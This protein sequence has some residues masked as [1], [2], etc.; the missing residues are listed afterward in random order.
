MATARRRTNKKEA[1]E[2]LGTLEFVVRKGTTVQ[3]LQVAM[4]QAARWA[5]DRKK[6]VD[7]LNGQLVTEETDRLGA[8]KLAIHP[9]VILYTEALDRVEKFLVAGAKL[10]LDAM[11]LQLAKDQGDRIFD[12]F[13]RAIEAA[14]LAP[15]QAERMRL[16][17]ATEL[18]PP[19]E[20][21][22]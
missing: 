4:D 19:G 16:A 10:G 14:E 11:K 8:H 21:A 13:T 3:Q 9:S 12:A 17:F 5:D 2:L 20:L 18:R 7:A 1:I 15:E 22:A 6:D